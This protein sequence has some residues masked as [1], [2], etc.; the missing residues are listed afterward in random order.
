MRSVGETAWPQA[1]EP[2]NGIPPLIGRTPV[3]RPTPKGERHFAGAKAARSGIAAVKMSVELAITRPSAQ[4]AWA[5]PF[6]A[7]TVG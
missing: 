7:A 1:I 5:T 6:R 4:N 2:F 3:R